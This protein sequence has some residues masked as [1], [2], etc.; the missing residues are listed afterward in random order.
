MKRFIIMLC[1]LV[2]LSLSACSSKD[3]H[4]ALGYI[5]GKYI[6]LSSSVSG[7]LKQRLV[8]R[9]DQVKA[10]QLLYKL[11]P[12]PEKSELANAQGVLS[13]AQEKL[14]DLMHGQRVTVLEQIVA[15]RKAA[16]ANL[17]LA[18]KNLK[19]YHQLYLDGAVGKAEYDARLA[20]YRSAKEAVKQQEANLAE[21]KL[22][23]RRHQIL[24]QVSAVEAAKATVAELKW[25]LN[26]KTM[27]AN[28]AGRVFDTF[29]RDGEYVPAGQAVLALLPSQNI[30]VK[31]F[32]PEAQLSQMKV[33]ESISFTCDSC[34]AAGHATIYYISPSAEYTP[35]VIYSQD[36]RVKLVYRI[37]ADMTPNEAVKFHP[38]QPV[39]V[40]FVS[41]AK[42]ASH[43]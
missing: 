38:G 12:N 22:G 40:H 26:E 1:S 14:S 20:D 7:V 3:A 28:K 39:V 25:K 34:K 4:I 17:V 35:P 21:N 16:Q 18:Q 19:R 41:Q 15:Q 43:G 10:G 6:Y 30:R 42:A 9:G 11:D 31:F 23:A 37:E 36:T 27:H 33:G 29:Y 32:V 2:F 8:R 5:D 24:A 13:E